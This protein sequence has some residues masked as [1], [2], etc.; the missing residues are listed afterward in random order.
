MPVI[1]G[2]LAGAGVLGA[3]A[4]ERVTRSPVSLTWYG[5]DGS[6]WDLTGGSAGVFLEDVLRGTGMPDPEHRWGTYPSS[7]GSEWQGL[8]YPAREFSAVVVISAGDPHDFESLSSR[9]M[10]SLHPREVG[11]LEARRALGETRRLMGCRYVD[12]A[13]GHPRDSYW[14]DTG[15]FGL[16]LLADPLWSGDELAVVFDN[17]SSTTTYIATSGAGWPP[18]GISSAATI[19]AATLTNPGDEAAWPVVRFSGPFTAASLTQDGGPGLVDIDATLTEGQWIEVDMRPGRKTVVDDTGANR[20][21]DL[22]TFRPF[23]LPV[24]ELVPLTLA[25]TGDGA[26]TSVTVRITPLYHAAW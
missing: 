24:G 25:T 13:S 22:D 20:R 4:V 26:A 18:Y 21:G 1:V 11:H 23:A 6:V 17:S 15:R 10:R 8:R 2:A 12:G 3:A 14:R 16:R 19:S 5:W 9:F 7:D